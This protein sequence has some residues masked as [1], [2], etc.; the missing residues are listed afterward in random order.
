MEQLRVDASNFNLTCSWTCTITE[1]GN[2]QTAPGKASR[3][4]KFDFAVPDGCTVT[5]AKMY[6]TLGSPFCGANLSRMNGV[7]VGVGGEKSVDVEIADGATSVTVTCEFQ[8]GTDSLA[9]HNAAWKDGGYKD[10]IVNHSSSLTYSSVYLL[11]NYE[12][13]GE[14]DSG[15]SDDSEDNP[16]GSGDSGGNGGNDEEATGIIERRTAH[17]EG[18]GLTSSFTCSETFWTRINVTTQEMQTSTTKTFYG[19]GASTDSKMVRFYLNM[20][21]GAVL[22]SAVVYATLGTGR[23]AADVLT[24][25]GRAATY[26][27]T[28]GVGVSTGTGSAYVDVRFA[29]K[30]DETQF[31]SASYSG[32]VTEESGSDNLGNGI[33]LN[34]VSKIYYDKSEVS[35]SNVYLVYEYMLPA[36]AW[37]LLVDEVRPGDTLGVAVTEPDAA[38]TYTAQAVMGEYSSAVVGIPADTLTASIPV[39]AA[40]LHAMPDSMTGVGSVIV[41]EYK[42]GNLAYE[43][44]RPF[45]L[46]CPES[47]APTTLFFV[48]HPLRTV[49][50]VTYPAPATNIYVRSKCGVFAEWA[51]V[52]AQYG[53][54]VVSQHINVG[55]YEGDAYN[56]DAASIESGLLMEAGDIPITLTV[57]DSRGLTTVKTASIRVAAYDPP[58]A[59]DFK[60]WRVNADGV[61]DALG[62]YAMCSFTPV[63]S[64]VASFLN[65]VTATLTVDGKTATV[66]VEPGVLNTFMLLP[67]GA[68]PLEDDVAYAVELTMTDLWESV[69]F[70][71][72]TIKPATGTTVVIRPTRKTKRRLIIGDYDTVAEANWTLNKLAFPEPEE[73][74]NFVTVPGRMAGPLDM[75]SVLTN[76]VP[77]YGSRT[78]TARLECSEGT[79][80]ERNDLISRMI[81]EL[82]GKRWQIV[83]PDDPDRYVVG[84]VSVKTEFSDP[85]HA[86]VNVSAVCEPWRYNKLETEIAYTVTPAEKEGVLSNTG[87]RVLV[88]SVRVEG[89]VL[90]T[91]DGNLWEMT[92]GEYHLPELLLHPGNTPITFSGD[93]RIVFVY[94]EAVL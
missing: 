30:C 34:H 87:R 72:G 8:P 64:N 26:G 81:N 67:G 52:S 62:Q 27:T 63:A 43:T 22:T 25:G 21:K 75:S 4:V 50:G 23:Y 47:A 56:A 3:S 69:T 86:A 11:I 71:A 46:I 93:G 6:A 84:R 44:A 13:P 68:V 89:T 14:G 42:D 94:R 74:T 28:V 15:E 61:S 66:E 5:G 7:P 82:D 91:C 58:S 55:G 88:P 24:V 60:A 90:L 76:G 9:S 79:R 33:W 2:S 20:P 51:G 18:F 80:Q 32:S 1:Q 29:Y 17:T 12:K 35:V 70:K 19:G 65:T 39:N 10:L 73:Q 85:A 31:N 45:T 77:V 83:L 78:L 57:T 53:A 54:S 92:E 38:R 49:D 40:W 16:G 48:A 37:D 59:T 41:R 36:T